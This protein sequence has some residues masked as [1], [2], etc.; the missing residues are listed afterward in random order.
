MFSSTSRFNIFKSSQSTTEYIP[1]EIINDKDDIT[2]S[3]DESKPEEE[4]TPSNNEC[5]SFT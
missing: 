2:I 3:L 4:L 1:L 5:L